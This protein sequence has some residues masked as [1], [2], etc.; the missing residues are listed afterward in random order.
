MPYIVT[1]KQAD[2]CIHCG[3]TSNLRWAG[4]FGGV[5]EYVCATDVCA[6]RGR[7]VATLE[8]ARDCAA[9]VGLGAMANDP[10]DSALLRQTIM[11]RITEQGG[12]IGPLPDGT[13]IEVEPTTWEA[14]DDATGAPHH[15]FYPLD[16]SARHAEIIDAYN[17]REV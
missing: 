5:A 15:R 3:A 13:V 8:E 1:T 16:E 4:S 6:R 17:A 7:A 9:L 11:L 14:L 10:P 2:G 12:T